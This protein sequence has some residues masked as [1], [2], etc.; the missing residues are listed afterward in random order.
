MKCLII[1]LPG[2]RREVPEMSKDK[3]KRAPVLLTIRRA[4]QLTVRAGNV[5]GIIFTAVWMLLGGVASYTAVL[6]A[7]FFNAAAEM[8]EGRNGAL[9]LALFWLSLW[10]VLE[11]GIAVV[12]ML[13]NRMSAVMANKLSC[14]IEEEALHKVGKLKLKY[15]DD[16]EAQRKIRMCKSN[17]GG[18]VSS[19]TN[20]SLGMIRCVI[21]CVTAAVILL[22][23]SWLITLIV[24]VCVFPAVFVMR[25]RND[26]YYELSQWNSFEGQMQRYLSLVISK[27]KYIKEMRFYQLYDYMEDKYE[28][29][30]KELNKQQM[31]LAGTFLFAESLTG[32]LLYGSIAVALALISW[33]IFQGK[34]AIGAFILIYTT[35][36]NMQGGLTS[37]F[38]CLETI[39]DEGRYLEDYEEVLSCEEEPLASEVPPETAQSLEIRFEHVFF[40]YPGTDREVLKDINITIHQGEKIAIVGENGSGKS[41]FVSL[42]EGLYEPVKGRILVNGVDITRNLGLL[43]GRLS[44]TSQEFLHYEGTLADNIRIGDAEKERSDDEVWQA[45]AKMGFEKEVQNLSNGMDTM[46]G[47]FV[48]GGIDLSG[49]QW[50]KLAIARNLLKDDALMMVLDE[51]TAALDPLAEAKL[52][53]QFQLLTKEKTVLLISHRLG[54][55]GLADRVLV[56]DDGQIKEDGSHEELLAADGLYKKMYEAQAQWYKG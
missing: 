10:A 13:Y 50:Q 9:K 21:S 8:L 35:V 46:L 25:K 53:E 45:L 34:A 40:A 17:F 48:P 20:A 28:D 55:T 38:S 7:K 19:V 36:Q 54:A 27:R 6:N 47:N 52:Y 11:I 22:R 43:R 42:L 37:A 30:V 1:R 16:R 18:H 32:I 51:P 15:F 39:T 41:T 23:T 14:F 56:F 49:G 4:I 33:K 2:I 3:R 26:R 12:E 5:G 29:S 44:C 24:I 31:K